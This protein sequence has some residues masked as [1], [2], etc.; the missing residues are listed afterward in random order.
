MISAYGTKDRISRTFLVN[1]F[2]VELSFSSASHLLTAIIRPR[3]RSCATPA[4]LASCSVTPSVASITR[5]T[6][7]ALSIAAI[8]RMILYLSISS[9]ILLLRRSPAVSI[10]T[11][12]VSLWTI[13][14][15]MASLVVPA[16]SETITRFSPNRRLI[17]EDL[18]AFG[19][20]TTAIFG[21]S[22]S[23]C[24][25]LSRSITSSTASSISPSPSLL[26]A[27]T[28]WGSPM[29]RL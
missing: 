27:D 9:L 12:S 14:V 29:P 2:T 6:T 8:V 13:S 3:P 26:L 17:S 19:F 18:P 24:S 1:S 5:I 4:I 25:I 10:N 7:S 11:Y 23:S 16:T 28:G 22:S 21:L 20:P 15:S